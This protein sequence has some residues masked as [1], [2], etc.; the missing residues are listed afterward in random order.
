ML[1]RW[2]GDAHSQ[3]AADQRGIFTTQFLQMTSNLAGILRWEASRAKPSGIAVFGQSFDS[4][5]H[6]K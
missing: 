2:D 1:F 4:P 3:F 5:E 6:A